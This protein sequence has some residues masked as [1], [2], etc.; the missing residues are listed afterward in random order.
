MQEA[1][2][3]AR[4]GRVGIWE[5][6]IKP[7]LRERGRSAQEIDSMFET[8]IKE[9]QNFSYKLASEIKAQLLADAKE[10]KAKLDESLSPTLFLENGFAHDD[11]DIDLP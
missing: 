9:G 2:A 1:L 7:S 8:Q 3:E 11:E 10:R 5:T 6:L 4:A